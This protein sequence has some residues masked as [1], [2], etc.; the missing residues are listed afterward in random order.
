MNT[1]FKFEDFEINFEE[2]LGKGGFGEVYKATEKKTGKVYVIKRFLKENLF[3][4]E[5]EN[6]KLLNNCENSIKYFDILKKKI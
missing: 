4:E 5:L 1:K 3:E 6:M 2:P